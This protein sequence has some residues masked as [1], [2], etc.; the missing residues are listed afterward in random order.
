MMFTYRGRWF[1]INL[2]E[3]IRFKVEKKLEEEGLLWR[4]KRKIGDIA[5]EVMKEAMKEW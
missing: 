2:E 1:N 3:Y 5:I 4:I